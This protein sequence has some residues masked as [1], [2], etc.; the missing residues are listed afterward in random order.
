MGRLHEMALGVSFFFQVP[1][2][3]LRVALL[4]RVF[5]IYEGN[6]YHFYGFFLLSLIDF[7]IFFSC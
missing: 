7:G 6:S 3:S 1:H 4:T 2:I 5:L